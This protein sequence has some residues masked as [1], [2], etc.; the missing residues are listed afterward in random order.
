MSG[1]ESLALRRRLVEEM[2]RRGALHSRRVEQ[3]FLAVPREWFLPGLPLEEVYADRSV[4][5]KKSGDEALSSSSQP[6][7][8]AIMFEQLAVREGDRVLEIGT[9]SG[10]NAALLAKLTGAQGSVTSLDIDAELVEA[11]RAR[12]A[13]HGGAVTLLAADAERLGELGERF[14]RIMVTVSAAEVSPQWF[15]S[16]REGG[17]LVVPLELGALQLCVAFERKGAIL[18]SGS[19]AG[20]AFIPLRG[21]A[22]HEAFSLRSSEANFA[23]RT[24]GAGGP[25]ADEAWQLLCTGPSS[26]RPA[27]V[28]LAEL[29]DVG[30]WL[31]VRD[32]GFCVLTAHGSAL[33]PGVV[34]SVLGWG[35]GPVESAMTFGYAAG[36]ALAVFALGPG[37]DVRIR[38]FGPPE[39]AGRLEAGLD[40][41]NAAG[42][43]SLGRMQLTV[44]FEAA[45]VP[46]QARHDVAG[47]DVIL[48]RPRSAILVRWL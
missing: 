6:S 26:D 47:G 4:V 42:R 21:A 5:I 11:A 32:S 40:A 43:P 48:E 28:G 24:A 25:S 31:D 46:R 8:M 34:P 2:R 36:D 37:G 38:G 12:F 27:A 41:W 30:R 9:G 14:D 1:L 22:Q 16:L 19:C 45:P 18:V 23:L 7:M 29:D 35:E 13:E 10:Y 3:A 17:R 33:E 44:S 20:T 15:A 39:L